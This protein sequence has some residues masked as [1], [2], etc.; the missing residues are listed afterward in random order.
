MLFKNFKGGFFLKDEKEINTSSDNSN[1]ELEASLDKTENYEEDQLNDELEKL[2]ETFR[3]ELNKA[4]EQGAVKIGEV[5]VVDEND[6]AIPKEELCDCC[7][8]RRKDISISA[9][10]QYF[11]C[12]ASDR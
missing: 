9:N 7:G 10:Y 4:K 11:P 8:E 2:A 12:F 1:E 3:K 6:N 5:A